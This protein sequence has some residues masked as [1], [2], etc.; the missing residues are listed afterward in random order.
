M[1]YMKTKS[2]IIASSSGRARIKTDVIKKKYKL[3]IFAFK[4]L[5]RKFNNELKYHK[6]INVDMFI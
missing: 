4:V 5:K 6:A 3:S 1:R 2:I